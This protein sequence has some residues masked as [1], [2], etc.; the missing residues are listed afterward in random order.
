MSHQDV[1]HNFPT[2]SKGDEIIAAVGDGITVHNKD[3]RIIYQN[4]VMKD[5]FGDRVVQTCYAAYNQTSR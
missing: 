3:F 5:I 2:A 1:A 4:Q